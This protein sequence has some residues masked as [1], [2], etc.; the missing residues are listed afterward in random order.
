MPINMTVFWLAVLVILVVIELFTM[1]L[2]TIWF[3]GGALVA[4]LISIPG[5]PVSLQIFAFLAVSAV[6]LY[7]TRPV[8]VKYFN[9]DRVR[10]NIESMVGRQAIVISEINNLEGV[11]Q[12]N[13]GGMEWS[14]RSSYNNV[15]LPVGAVVTILGVDGVKLIVE[16]RREG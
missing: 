7:F 6:L 13:T 9:R 12:V 14:A 5:L 15:V 4:A 2:T 10:T 11:G 16:E 1:G 3:A 8:A